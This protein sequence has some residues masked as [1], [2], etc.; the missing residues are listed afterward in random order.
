MKRSGHPHPCEK[1]RRRDVEDQETSH[2]NVVN[3]CELRGQTREAQSDQ[4][5]PGK[6]R[7]RDAA[8]LGRCAEYVYVDLLHLPSKRCFQEPLEHAE[9]RIVDQ[10]I[11]FYASSLQIRDKLVHLCG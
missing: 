7:K 2:G 6:L 8:P 9:S 5:N 4:R 3:S 10:Q 1:D 11:D